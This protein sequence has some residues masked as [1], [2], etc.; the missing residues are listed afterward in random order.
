MEGN[1]LMNHKLKQCVM[2]M[3]RMGEDPEEIAEACRETLHY[4][5]SLKTYE[6][7]HDLADY[8]RAYKDA[9]FRP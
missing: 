2:E 1:T 5:H 8:Y 4:M 7:N 3:L 6:P 9:D